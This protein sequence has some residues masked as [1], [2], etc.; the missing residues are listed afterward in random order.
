MGLQKMIISALKS[1]QTSK[2]IAPGFD[3]IMAQG[4]MPIAFAD[5]RQAHSLPILGTYIQDLKG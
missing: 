2:T 1:S 3:T 4:I 5:T